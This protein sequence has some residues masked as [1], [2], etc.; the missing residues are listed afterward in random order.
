MK[1]QLKILYAV[2]AVILLMSAGSAGAAT[3]QSS[4]IPPQPGSVVIAAPV[5]AYPY[6]STTITDEIA[7]QERI[8]ADFNRVSSRSEP[9][10]LAVGNE[11]GNSE[12]Y[13]HYL[14]YSGVT[15]HSIKNGNALN[16]HEQSVPGVGKVYSP[17]NHTDLAASMDRY[18]SQLRDADGKPVQLAE[19]RAVSTNTESGGF[20]EIK[21]QHDEIAIR[22]PAAIVLGLLKNK[23][24]VY[25]PGALILMTDRAAH[26]IKSTLQSDSVVTKQK[27]LEI[28]DG[29]ISIKAI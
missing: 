7:Q 29:V 3:I 13:Q 15:T 22:V 17:L 25:A 1:T 27:G 14:R 21:F 5:V 19:I 26:A 10:I 18:T 24:A 9:D 20:F 28:K 23:G 8:N 12:A 6:S 4:L 2:S 11:D 16:M